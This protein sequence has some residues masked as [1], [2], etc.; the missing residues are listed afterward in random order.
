[1]Q[2]AVQN[3]SIGSRTRSEQQSDMK[4]DVGGESSDLRNRDI[5][6]DKVDIWYNVFPPHSPQFFFK[7]VL[8]LD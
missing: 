7:L 1:M 6:S 3:S 5:G 2:T 4:R 8:V